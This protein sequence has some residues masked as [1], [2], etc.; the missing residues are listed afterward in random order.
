MS[1]TTEAKEANAIIREQARR[2]AELEE[3]LNR[4]RG[5]ITLASG[6]HATTW[7][8]AAKYVAAQRD[9]FD[10]AKGENAKLWD[11]LPKTADGAPIV[12]GGNLYA[13]LKVHDF[14]TAYTV[15]P[16][17]FIRMCELGGVVRDVNGDEWDAD[18]DECYSTE[19]AALAATKGER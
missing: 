11:K 5:A 16:C 15:V 14:P 17:G 3:E 19:A 4:W 6:G 1:T 2:I 8:D 7:K 10:A 9:M 12:P 18:Y 13:R